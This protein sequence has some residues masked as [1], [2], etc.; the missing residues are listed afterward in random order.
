M[1]IEVVYIVIEHDGEDDNIIGV[2][3]NEEDA[4][5]EAKQWSAE[6]GITVEEHEIK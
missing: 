2:Y 5:E 1:D 6:R 3:A 4:E